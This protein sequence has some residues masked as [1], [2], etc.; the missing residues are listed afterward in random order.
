MTGS[1][2]DRFEIKDRVALEYGA[3]GVVIIF[4]HDPNSSLPTPG[5]AVLLVRQDGWLYAGRAEDVRHEPAAETSGLFLRGLHND[6]VP[7]G[8][9]LR[10]GNEIRILENAAVA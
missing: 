3:A 1:V 5:E 10:W 7:I 9:T 4:R 2:I 6:D 8:S